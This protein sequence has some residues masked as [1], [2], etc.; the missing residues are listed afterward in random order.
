MAQSFAVQIGEILVQRYGVRQGDLARALEAQATSRTRLCSLLIATG[1]LDFDDASRALGEQKGLPCALGKHLEQRDVELARLVPEE[2]GRTACALPIGRTSNGS[3]IVCARDP[4][5]SLRLELERATGLPVML[6]I[7]PA[8][9]LEDLVT[10]AYGANAVEEFDVDFSSVVQP[11]PDLASLD[12]ESVRFALT[13]LDDERV[14]KDPSQSGSMNARDALA[15]GTA[16]PRPSTP[17]SFDAMRFALERAA[18]R[19]AATDLAMQFVAQRWRAGVLLAIRGGTAAGYRGHGLNQR[20]LEGLVLPLDTPSTVQRAIEARRTWIQPAPGPA[21]DHLIRVLGTTGLC[22]APVLAN[23]E[24]VAVLVVGEPV[25][26]DDVSEATDTSI[27]DLGRLADVLGTAYSRIRR[28]PSVP[29][30][31]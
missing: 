18:S 7:A 9:R 1:V 25:R 17:L 5:D 10:A 15:I 11:T 12:A 6:V 3:L 23:E 31:Q 14:A 28:F 2:L 24:V 29:V 22:A 8:L 13:D 26:D 16:R 27:T 19:D 21:Q 30:G 20:E 4:S